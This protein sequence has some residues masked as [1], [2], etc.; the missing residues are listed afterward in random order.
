MIRKFVEKIKE[1]LVEKRYGIIDRYSEDFMSGQYTIS[2][3]SNM[4]LY[5]D[6]T[7]G[8]FVTVRNIDRVLIDTV[9]FTRAE[10]RFLRKELRKV[11]KDHKKHQKTVK[12]PEKISDKD[13]Y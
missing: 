10:K 13:L 2:I 8:Y 1:I 12:K 7:L 11:I 3:G 5:C 6:L 4:D 9:F